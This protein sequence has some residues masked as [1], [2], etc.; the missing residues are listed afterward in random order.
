ES[1]ARFLVEVAP[2]HAAQFEATLAGRPAARIGRVNSERMLRVQGL[3]GGGVICCDV[4]QLV[5][6]WQSAEVV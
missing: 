5:Q 4:A 1:N 2:E 3:R 6:A